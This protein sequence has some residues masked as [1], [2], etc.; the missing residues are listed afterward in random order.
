[1]ITPKLLKQF[2]VKPDG[3][4][5]LKNYVTDWT[6]TDNAKELG[7]DAIKKPSTEEL[8]HNFLW[9]YMKALPERGRIGI[10]NR[11]YYEE[12]LVTRVHPEYLANQQVELTK[13]LWERRFKQINNYEKHLTDNGTTIIK[14]F[15]YISRDEQKKR[16][17]ERIERPEKNWKFSPQDVR[18]RG[19][20]KQ[21]MEAYEDCF[22]HTSTKWAPWYVIPADAKW[23]TRLCVAD[24]IY[25]T[26]RKMNP[27]FPELSKEHRA[28][29][30]ESKKLLM[31]EKS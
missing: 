30:A 4:V 11:S 28:Q 3:E 5:D 13:D 12:V 29:L 2:L 8:D 7:E 27:T 21:Y 22:N 15:L 31:E 19:F 23:F 16:F 14:F 26:L 25:E 9:R 17:L 10:F 24:V 6:G 20:W 18:E 1:M